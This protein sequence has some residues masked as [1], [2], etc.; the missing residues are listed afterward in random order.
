VSPAVTAI[1]PLA[2]EQ[3]GVTR[4]GR[5]LFAALTFQIHAGQVLVIRGANGSGKTTLLRMLAGLTLPETGSVSWAARPWKPRNAEQRA[6]CLYLGHLHA[7]KDELN[8]LQNL[9][10]A[11]AIDGIVADDTAC[12]RALDAAGLA[13]R[14]RVVARRLSQGQ[15]RRV[16]LARLAM[17]EKPLWLLDE[18]TN[19]LDDDGIERFSGL[20][21]AHVAKGGMAAIAT[22]LPL[23][24]RA[25]QTELRI[26]E[27]A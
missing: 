3:L 22:H 18:P 11:L 5:Q 1:G 16:G 19:A 27:A 10:F 12:G 15:K 23:A 21:S 17:S 14:H 20:I 2:A 9:K 26:G 7:L 4:G 8:A 6:T 24:L 25:P 13:G